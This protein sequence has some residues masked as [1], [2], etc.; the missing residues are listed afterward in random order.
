MTK[1][2]VKHKVGSKWK[3]MRTVGK[4]RTAVMVHKVGKARYKIR[5]IKPKG[6]R[7]RASQRA[8]R[9]TKRGWAMDRKLNSQ[10]PWEVARRR[11]G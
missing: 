5:V 2:K 10:E 3:A 11:R 4:R 8:H 7:G 6:K 1:R 9:H